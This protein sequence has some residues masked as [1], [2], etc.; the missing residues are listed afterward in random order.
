MMV[1]MASRI[2]NVV[3]ALAVLS[4]VRKFVCVRGAS[5]PEHD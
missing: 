3:L 1:I 2:A 4:A 5:L